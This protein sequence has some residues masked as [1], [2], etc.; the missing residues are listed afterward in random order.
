M[1]RRP[2]WRLIAGLLAGAVASAGL[3]VG[4]IAL[5][6]LGPLPA[7]PADLLARDGIRF[8]DRNGRILYAPADSGV[9]RTVRLDEMS[10]SLR[11]AVLATEDAAFYR[12]PGVNPFAIVRSA[13]DNLREDRTVS[14]AGTITQQVIRGLYLTPD[15]P[16]RSRWGRKAREGLLALRLTRR[17]G[18][19][20]VLGL[21]LNHA[22][23]GNLAYGVEAAAQAYF[24][25][26]ARDLDLAESAL[27]IGLI[28]SPARYDPLRYP[29]AARARQSDVL[30]LMVRAG[31]IDHD[32]AATALGEP[33][34]F[35][36]TPFPIAAPHFTAF[37]REQLES[38][39]GTA[40][41]HGGLRVVTTLDLG[42]QRTAEEAVRRRLAALKDQDVSNGAVVAIN[43]ASGEVL[44]MV[45]SA[46]YFDRSIDGAVNL[47]IA[48][49]QPGSAMKPLLYA[50]ALEGE[51]TP[52]TPLTDVRTA[53]TT[54][55]GELYSP[56]NYDGKFH[57]LLPAREALAGSYNVP[58][59]RLLQQIGIP[60]FLAIASAGGI[61]TLG[62]TDRFDLSLILGGGE[63]PLLELTGAY[64]ALAN[65]GERQPLVAMLRVENA[66]GQVVWRP[67]PQPAVRVYSPE[68]AWLV[69]DILADNEA[70]TPAFGANSPLRVNRPAAAKTGTTSDFRDNWTVGYT[71][72]LVVG[73]WVG[74]ADNR[75]MKDVSGISGAA[76]IWHDVIEDA[77][78]GRPPRPFVRPPG[79]TQTEVCLPSGLRPTETCGRRRL[80]WFKAGMEPEH[81]D[82]YYRVVPVCAGT[83]LAA[84][85]GCPE[86]AI[87][88]RVFEFP[89]DEVIP[90]ARTAGVNLPP[91][92]GY[93]T[94][95]PPGADPRDAPR[96][97]RIVRPEPGI[98]V[99]ISRALPAEVQA[100]TFEAQVTGNVPGG[101]R[102]EL[103]GTP[104]ALIASAPYK[105]AWPLAVGT[106]RLRVSAELAN[107]ETAAD[108]I[109]FTVLGPPML[110]YTHP[111]P[112]QDD[113][114]IQP[115]WERRTPFVD[116]DPPTTARLLAPVFGNQSVV[117]LEPL[118]DGLANTNY[119]VHMT[120]GGP[121]V[122]LRLYMRDPEAWAREAA[123]F[124]RVK[125][126]VPVPEL[127]FADGS[128]ERFDRPYAVMSW[129]D[130]TSPAE[131]LAHGGP[132]DAAAIGQAVGRTL[133]AIGG[134]TFDGPG[135]LAPDLSV[136]PFAD[137]QMASFRGYIR[138][139]LFERDAATPVDKS[140]AEDIWR[141]VERN[142][143]Y[144]PQ[145]P[146]VAALVHADYKFGNILVHQGQDSWQV[147]AVLDWE[148]AFAG[149]P[150]FDLSILLRYAARLPAAF[151]PGVI[152]G[153]TAAGGALPDEWRRTVRLLDFVNL[154]DFLTSARSDAMVSDIA[155][156]INGTMQQWESLH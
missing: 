36:P 2:R 76:P 4:V 146:A 121:P 18:K 29:D 30:N 154:C 47:T 62:E 103:D 120:G 125:D 61:T 77:L 37:V 70:R 60:R 123:L 43:P 152:A 151:E 96:T 147:A 6:V 19:D 132:S 44:A 9:R 104:L 57:G 114:G 148:F 108:E 113:L 118:S 15:G 42:L 82:D 88:E 67:K 141:F 72:D 129:V 5:I 155:S 54:R 91:L 84:T 92:P 102:F 16:A 106:H 26:P 48:P 10:P 8:E 75:S 50:L 22:Y 85:T 46:D 156:L 58:A 99:R 40:A 98:T 138:H 3:L 64:T 137:G 83:G 23:F 59:V 38:E 112:E 81:N 24:G 130:G 74:N 35:S 51:I 101:V 100:L 65:G 94:D 49:R 14:G 39:L 80:E 109:E 21:Y 34:T 55:A 128:G 107:G 122:V 32:Q 68:A 13:L 1:K 52:A 133:A 136:R 105:L 145:D 149:P 135:E 69:T 86:G 139:C 142:A 117:S 95:V 115:G 89:P 144:F 127:L 78:T 124:R 11:A 87:V 119:R 20:E 45:G 143:G 17:L 71:P 27:L 33:L 153:Y 134:Y 66:H 126:T 25:R 31:L 12:H 56:N 150:I 111:M 110:R 73:V 53:F 131:A 63:T 97:L 93:R 140:F 28:Q 7:E 116:L 41:A 90:W 79:V